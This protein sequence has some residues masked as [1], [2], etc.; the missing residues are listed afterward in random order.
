MEFLHIL[1]C[2][3]HQFVGM[4]MLDEDLIFYNSSEI[5]IEII[6]LSFSVFAIPQFP[7]SNFIFSELTENN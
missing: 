4:L 3:S 7:F 1:V 2:P 5:I 6:V